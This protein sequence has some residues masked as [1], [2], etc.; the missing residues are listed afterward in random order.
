MRQNKTW[1]KRE[2]KLRQKQ[3]KDNIKENVTRLLETE[4]QK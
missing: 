3:D 1:A 2:K 4:Q